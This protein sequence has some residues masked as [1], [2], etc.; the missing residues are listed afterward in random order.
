[1]LVVADPVIAR[2]T[3]RCP[4]FEQ[5]KPF[6]VPEKGLLIDFPPNGCSRKQSPF[7]VG[8]EP[9]G[10]VVA[11]TDGNQVPVAEEVLRTPEKRGGGTLA[12]GGAG[13]CRVVGYV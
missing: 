8:S 12:N 3:H 2:L 13:Q 6:D 5:R 1:M 9:R 7:A 11:C 4:D 10:P